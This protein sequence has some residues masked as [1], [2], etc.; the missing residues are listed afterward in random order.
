DG[1]VLA[2]AGSD[3]IHVWDLDHPA[4]PR[5]VCKGHQSH[6]IEM[7]FTARS[8]LL[9]SHSWDGT[10]RLWDAWIGK[11]LLTIPNAY[12]QANEFQGL[13][14]ER[15]IDDAGRQARVLELAAGDVCRTLYAHPHPAG[16]GSPWCVDFSPDGRRLASAGHDGVYLWDQAADQ[17]VAHLPVGYSAHSQFAPD[18]SG[19]FTFGERGLFRWPLARGGLPTGPPQHFGLESPGGWFRGSADREGR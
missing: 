5:T 14:R 19:L 15:A 7:T 1:R 13:R 10:V 6:G 17:Q 16:N 18:G 4:Q 12:L 11:E 8:D 9:L 3:V 2:V